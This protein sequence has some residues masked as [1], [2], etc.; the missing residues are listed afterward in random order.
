MSIAK[1]FYKRLGLVEHGMSNEHI[2]FY[3]LNGVVLSVYGQEALADD[4][5]KPHTAIP[6]FRGMSLAWNV[7]SPADVDAV[8]AQAVTAGATLVKAGQ[9]VFW[10]GYS[11]YFSDPDGHLWEV[12]HNP[13]VGF[14]AQMQLVLP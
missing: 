2:G 6:N 4:A 14:N 5:Q 7:E 12:A 8:L 11:G 10:G 9:N 13:F 3:D 1:A